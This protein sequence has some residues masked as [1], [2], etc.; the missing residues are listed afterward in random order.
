MLNGVL[1][2]RILPLLDELAPPAWA[3]SWDRVG[4]QLGDADAVINK[5][6]VCLDV[7]PQ[8]VTEADQCDAQ[9]IISH[10]PLFLSALTSLDF[11]SPLGDLIRSLIKA[12]LNVYTAHT[13]LDAAPEGVNHILARKIGLQNPKVLQSQAEKLNK[14]VVFVPRK[15]AQSVYEAMAKAGAGL[16]GSYSHCSFWLEGTGTFQPAKDAQPFIGQKGELNRVPEVRIE[17]LVTEGR[18]PQVMEAIYRTHPYEEVACDIYPVNNWGKSLGLGRIGSLPQK[19]TAAEFCAKLKQTLGLQALRLTGN[20]RH[21]VSRVAVCSGSGGSFISMAKAAGADMLVTGDIKYHQARE[22]ES[23][24]LAVADIGH[25][26]S[27]KII[28]AEVVTKLSR[29]LQEANHPV[30]VMGSGVEKD[31]FNFI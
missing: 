9:L 6:L 13:N 7:S 1:L 17:S 3:Q 14:V 5:I 12:G 15:Q 28:V 11:R 25:Y 21:P 27:E 20:P 31:V 18:L 19:M 10:H 22:A 2:H 8:V 23:L 24:G 16:I 29:L 4:L 26:H 30:E